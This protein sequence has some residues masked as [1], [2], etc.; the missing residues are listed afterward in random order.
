[1]YIVL[2]IHIEQTIPIRSN[3]YRCKCNSEKFLICKLCQIYAL[4]QNSQELVFFEN[5]GK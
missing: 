4:Q 3:P 2:M 5:H 1:M